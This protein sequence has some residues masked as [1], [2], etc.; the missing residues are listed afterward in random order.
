[1]VRDGDD[2]GQ[3]RD[4]ALVI[5]AVVIVDDLLAEGDEKFAKREKDEREMGS[6]RDEIRERERRE[7]EKREK[8][9]RERERTERR[10]RERR[11]RQK[12]RRR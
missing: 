12:Q 7:R 5:F 9:K 2:R 6:E 3:G 10:K 11:E 8:K 4:G 1:M